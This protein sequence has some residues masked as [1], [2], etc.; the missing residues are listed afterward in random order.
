MAKKDFNYRAR[1]TEDFI[2]K[3]LLFCFI[4]LALAG[5]LLGNRIGK[6]SKDVSENKTQVVTESEKK[7]DNTK[8]R[9]YPIDL[10]ILLVGGGFCSIMIV[11]ERKKAKEKLK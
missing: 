10:G 5:L 9:F 1:K 3:N 4:A 7:N 6:S 2:R 8:W 11:R